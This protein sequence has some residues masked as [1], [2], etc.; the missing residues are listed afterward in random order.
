M[1]EKV[2]DL[3]LK[4]DSR[5]EETVAHDNEEM[6]KLKILVENQQ[7]EIQ[8]LKQKAPASSLFLEI[9]DQQ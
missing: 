7:K 3:E 4:L 9:R 8:D 5:R 6:G 2:Y 1:E